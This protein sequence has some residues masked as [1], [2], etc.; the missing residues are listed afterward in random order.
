MAAAGE[1]QVYVAWSPRKYL[2]RRSAGRAQRGVVRGRC[3]L[4]TRI[5]APKNNRE[6]IGLSDKNVY[7]AQRYTFPLA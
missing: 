7:Q 4:T 1:G 6:M 2:R 3:S 5:S